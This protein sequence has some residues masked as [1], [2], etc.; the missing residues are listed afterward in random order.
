MT[1]FGY[2]YIV[3]IF[4]A[5]YL[6][7]YFIEKRTMTDAKEIIEKFFDVLLFYAGISIIYFSLTGKPFFGDSLQ[8]YRLYIF[9]V[10]FI[11]IIWSVPKLLREFKYLRRK[12]DLK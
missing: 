4:I 1:E 9:I 3:V 12:L 6:A 11:S 2:V 10:G 8:T 5:Y 7:I